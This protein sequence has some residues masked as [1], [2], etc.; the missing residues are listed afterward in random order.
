[1]PWKHCAWGTCKSGSR[2]PDKYPGVTFIAIVKPGRHGYHTERCLRW[3]KAS[4][5]PHEQLN[6]GKLTKHFY[7]YNKEFLQKTYIGHTYFIIITYT[8]PK[9]LL[10]LVWI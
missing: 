6:I 8:A 5:R 3:I 9:V 4:G 1:M 2:Y 7:I 10:D